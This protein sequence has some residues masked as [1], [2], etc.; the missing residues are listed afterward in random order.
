MAQSPIGMWLKSA[1]APT[2]M[3]KDIQ[4]WV[5]GSTITLS[6]SAY[7]VYVLDSDTGVAKNITRLPVRP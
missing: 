7:Q 6:G 4:T 2:G 5:L 3:P 1:S